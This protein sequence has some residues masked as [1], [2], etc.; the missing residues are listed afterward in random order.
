M[1]VTVS[2]TEDPVAAASIEVVALL[3]LVGAALDAGDEYV[4]SSEVELDTTLLEEDTSVGAIMTDGRPPV[5][6]ESEDGSALLGESV[7]LVVA[8]DEVSVTTIVDAVEVAV[9][10][11]DDED[12]E[13]VEEGTGLSN[14]PSTRD[15]MKEGIDD[16][17]ATDSESERDLSGLE[18]DVVVLFENCLFA[19]RGK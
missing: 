19:A 1:G 14:D 8:G 11:T 3:K 6:A 9:S 10:S 15:A 7:G 4:L 5:D 16:D 17:D 2:A 12:G 13:D 18:V